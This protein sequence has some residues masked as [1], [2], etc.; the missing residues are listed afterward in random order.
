[1]KALSLLILLLTFPLLT[2]AT[3]KGPADTKRRA[4]WC[5]SKLSKC[6]EDAQQ[7]CDDTWSSTASTELALCKASEVNACKNTYGSTSDCLTRDRTNP[8]FKKPSAANSD[9]VVKAPRVKPRPKKP[10]KNS[11]KNKKAR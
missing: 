5:E 11:E 7:D 10:K 2:Y 1:M 6:I 9:N 8:A 4:N 3:P